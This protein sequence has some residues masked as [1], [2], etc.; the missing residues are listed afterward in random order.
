[1]GEAIID[2]IRTALSCGRPACPCG[3]PAA[4]VTHCPAHADRHPSLVLSERG[5]RLLVHDRAGCPQHRVV[6]ELK[7]RGLWPHAPRPRRTRWA[8]PRPAP[9]VE[10]VLAQE[11]RQAARRAP[12]R[13]ANC[14]ADEVR[15][16]ERAVRF[17]R[18]WAG[19]LGDIEASWDLLAAAGVLDDEVRGL[20]EAWSEA[21]TTAAE[22]ARRAHV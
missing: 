2:R 8:G 15:D 22:A 10:A 14:L 5:G 20:E 4:R 16:T 1:M 11:A 21:L 9:E 17:L 12:Y 6:A 3:R 19:A 18:E 7:S 13:F